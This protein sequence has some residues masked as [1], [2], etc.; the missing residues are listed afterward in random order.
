MII[1]SG[2]RDRIVQVREKNPHNLLGMHVLEKEKCI[3]VRAMLSNAAEVEVQPVYD[4]T[5][6]TFKLDC[7]HPSGLFEGKTVAKGI[8]AYD[9]VITDFQGNVRRTR[10]PYSFLPSVDSQAEYLIGKGDER[11]LY[12]KLGAHVRVYDGVKG[13]AFAVWA[14]NALRVSVV[15]GFNNWDGRY[16]PMRLLGTSGIWEIFIPNLDVG[17]CYKYE[18]VDSNNTLRLKTDPMGFEFEIAPHTASVITDL[19]NYSWGDSE[20]IKNRRNQDIFRSPLSIYEIHLGSWKKKNMFESYSYREIAPLLIEYV[21]RMGFSHVE[22][23]PLAEHVYYPSWGY[24]VTG[25]YAPTSRY[26]SPEDFMYLVDQLHQSGVGVIMDWVPAH[27]PMDEFGLVRFDGTALYEH[28]DPRQ[29]YHQDW[30]TMIFNYGRNEVR[31]YLIANALFW[32][33]KYH[34]DGLRVDAVASILYLDYSRREGQW[35]P[36]KYGGRENLEAIEF[37]R[38]FNRLTH[39]EFPGIIT[40][41]EESTSWAQVTRPTYTG[42]LGFDFKWNMGWM[43][44]T[45]DYFQKEPI[46]RQYHHNNLTFG[47]LYNYHENFILPLS[48][49]EVVHGKASLMQKMPGDD[50][51]KAANL[52]ALLAWQ[53]CYPGRKLI[54]M[55][56]ELG[57]RV[58][59]N[60]NASVPWDILEKGPYHIGVQRVVQDLNKLYACEE[61]LWKDDYRQEGFEWLDCNNYQQSTYAFLRKTD[62]EKETLLV[63]V[64]LTPVPREGF[65]VGLPTKGKW[66]ELLNTDAS[67]YAG[68]NMGNN[69]CVEAEDIKYHNQ[70][71]SAMFTLPP[72]SVCIFKAVKD[73]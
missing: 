59:W 51:Q 73:L 64:N 1:S 25:Y 17:I 62:N 38:E 35:I 21:K 67:V 16:H 2:D 11:C 72:L 33:E 18:I 60:E 24:Q 22:F 26:G 65:R 4:K 19:S 23:L 41:A 12:D 5:R 46:Y 10:D 48:H 58:E 37:L 43:H 54:F 15:G 68:S 40:I 47:M 31:N 56:G 32:I 29:G 52:R 69:G 30:G 57:Q 45:L 13:V 36:N 14:P 6:P 50:W 53:W 39:T 20:W 63:V 42:G 49:D 55:G 7:I 61:A 34:I 8:Y 71:Y 9:L 3:V 66:K 27:F 44:D 70:P 28:A